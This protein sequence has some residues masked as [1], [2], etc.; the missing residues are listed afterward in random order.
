MCFAVVQQALNIWNFSLQIKLM[1]QQSKWYKYGSVN[2]EKC[3][4]DELTN[5]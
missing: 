4:N 1:S 3:S 2:I 5:V